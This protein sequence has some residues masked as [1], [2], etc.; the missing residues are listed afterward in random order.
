[1]SLWNTIL[2]ADE[3]DA[4]WERIAGLDAAFAA[5]A[6]AFWDSKQIATP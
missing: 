6:R 2:T 3:L 5:R 1:M 4:R